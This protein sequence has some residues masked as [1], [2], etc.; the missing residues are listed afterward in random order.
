MRATFFTCCNKK[1]EYFIPI[2][3]HSI[4]YH[5]DNVDVEIGIESDN[6]SLE[7]QKILNYFNI[8]YPKTN[9]SI[10][11]VNFDKITIDGRVYSK[12]PNVVRFI[13]TPNI[14]NEYVYICDV[15]II[16]LQKNI[17]QIHIDDMK[18]TGLSYSNIVRPLISED[19]NLKMLTGLHF[20]KWDA[21]YP[22]PNYTDLILKN[23]LNY[24]ESFLYNL[25]KKNNSILETHNF[26]PVHGIHASSNRIIGNELGWGL[27]KWRKEWEF[28]RNSNEF[29]DIEGLFNNQIKAIIKMI[30]NEY[31]KNENIFTDK[32]INNSWGCNESK[33]GPGSTLSANI[34]LL[35][36]IESFISE[37]DIKTIIDLGCGDFNWMKKFDFNLI[38][39]YLGV[40]VVKLIINDNKKY[41]TN[42]IKFKESDITTDKI[43]YFDVILCKDVLFHLSYEDALNVISIIKKSKSK[44]LISTT[45]LNYENKD[46]NTGE[47]RP[48]NLKTSPFSLGEPFLLWENI[49][50][51]AQGWTSKSIGIWKL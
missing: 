44:Y 11:K 37:Y 26:R 51:K 28:Y 25:V 41:E 9:I 46:I 49:E 22:I 42:K 5:N 43:D 40:D 38:D 7:L 3:I 15:D 13:N 39:L 14:K 2:F 31:M 27:K 12:C 30:D 24:D 8:K 29:K 21:Y 48:I 33:S 36:N 4:I 35:S 19:E 10:Y 34:K 6:I 45:F 1:Y 50:N 47:W 17:I 32:Y 18:K 16:T 20:T 23:M